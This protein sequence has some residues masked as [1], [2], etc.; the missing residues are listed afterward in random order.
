[1]NEIQSSIFEKQDTEESFYDDES[2]D[3]VIL[4]EEANI[5]EDSSEI[6]ETS[7]HRKNPVKAIRRKCLDCCGGSSHEVSL[8]PIPSCPI[9]PFRFG[10][11]P[12]RTKREMSEA[13]RQ[14]AAERLRKARFSINSKSEQYSL[15]EA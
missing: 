12:F 10:K 3:D 14:E 7:I 2:E 15:S 8:C 6:E 1:M 13:Q 9:F 11:N 4:S 5:E